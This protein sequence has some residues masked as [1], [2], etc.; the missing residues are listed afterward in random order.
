MRAT[1]V[2]V[3]TPTKA[4]RSTQRVF[5]HTRG[6]AVIARRGRFRG[7]TPL[8]RPALTLYSRQGSSLRRRLHGR[9][10]SSSASWFRVRPSALRPSGDVGSRRCRCWE[11]TA[12]GVRCSGRRCQECAD[13]ETSTA[14]R[15]QSGT[16]RS[17][18]PGGRPIPLI[19]VI[20]AARCFRSIGHT[21]GA[22]ESPGANLAVEHGYRKEQEHGLRAR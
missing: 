5:S 18:A 8:N 4:T 20:V 16:L 3:T 7:I 19:R 21:V 6:A 1:S 13:Q 12:S 22:T 14:H 11:G 2:S 17:S 10:R 9:L 15:R